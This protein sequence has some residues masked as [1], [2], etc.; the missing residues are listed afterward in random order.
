MKKENIPFE[1]A[2]DLWQAVLSG[3]SKGGYPAG[4]AV[5]ITKDALDAY[6]L[7]AARAGTY[8]F[9][10]DPEEPSRPL[11]QAAHSARVQDRYF[12]SLEQAE[13][14]ARSAS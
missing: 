11:K 8:E 5:Q 2:Y 9:A 6:D 12:E 3:I 13:K 7:I 1:Q 4:W 14:E 10:P